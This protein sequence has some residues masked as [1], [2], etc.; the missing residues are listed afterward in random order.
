MRSICV[1]LVLLWSYVGMAAEH[2]LL[3]CQNEPSA[4]KEAFKLRDKNAKNR[5]VYYFDDRQL[6]FHR[7]GVITRVRLEKKGKVKVDVK[8]RP[9][10][11]S[12]VPAK[13]RRHPDV[14]CE[15]DVYP[16]RKTASCALRRKISATEAQEILSSRQYHRFLSPVQRQFVR[17]IKGKAYPWQTLQK[18]GPTKT[19]KWDSKR[20]PLTLEIVH[21][22]NGL[23]LG[24]LSTR[25][26]KAGYEVGL[27]K[28]AQ[29]KGLTICSQQT[30]KTAR[31]LAS[32]LQR[33]VVLN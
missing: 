19:Q 4:I 6:R 29:Q 18:F 26:S 33:R 32:F 8:L 2:H 1:V 24:E 20:F 16:K 7:D 13:W 12:T 30:G 31:I 23:R 25:T 17:E 5:V 21:L 9:L 15:Y 10:D 28:M 11:L 14:S 22:V 3:L 27:V